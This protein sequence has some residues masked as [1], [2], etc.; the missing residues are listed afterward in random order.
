MPSGRERKLPLPL[1]RSRSH[2]APLIPW[3]NSNQSEECAWCLGVH[4]GW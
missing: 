2:H 1:S 4:H 3:K